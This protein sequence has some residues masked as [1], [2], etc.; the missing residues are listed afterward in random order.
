[1]VLDGKQDETVGVLL[2]QRL[3][4]LDLSSIDSSLGEFNGLLSG[5]LGGRRVGD[6]VRNGGVLLS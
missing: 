5:G 2:K 6:R 4:G 3:V 1:M